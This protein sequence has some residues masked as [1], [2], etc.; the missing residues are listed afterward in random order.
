MNQMRTIDGLVGA[1]ANGVRVAIAVARFNAFISE[2][3]LAGATRALLQSGVREAD[4]T[5]VRIP[6]AFELP[7]TCKHLAQTRRYD[8]VIALGCVIRGGTPHFE[9]VAGECARGIAQ[10]QLESGVP[11]MFGVLTTDTVEQS[12][13]RAN[14]QGE[15][16]GGEVALAALEMINVLRQIAAKQ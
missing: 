12:V 14:V 9:Y 11:V 3:L 8:A 10:V 16:K 2:N 1:S 4:V 7:V 5:I 15:N 13:E 6:G